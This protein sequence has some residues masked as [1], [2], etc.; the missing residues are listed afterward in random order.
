V[1][2]H[3]ADVPVHPFRK[4][5]RFFLHLVRDVSSSP[6]VECPDVFR[7]HNSLVPQYGIAAAPLAR[8]PG[9]VSTRSGENKSQDLPSDSSRQ[10]HDIAPFWQALES[11]ITSP[12]QQ[13]LWSESCCATLPLQGELHFVVV[14]TGSQTGAIAPLV[15]A[16]GVI[17]RLEH[18]GVRLLREPTDLVFSDPLVLKNLANSL[19]ELGSPLFLDRI[20]ADS[21]TVAAIREAYRGRGLVVIRRAKPYPRILL[22]KGWRKPESQL[23][24]GRRSDLR[25]AVRNAEKIGPLS[26]QILS[27]TPSQIGPILEEALDVEAA[28]WKGS[29]RSA[30]AN[31]KL[32][33]QFYRH[34]AAAA[35]AEGILR[36]CFLRVGSKAAAMQLALESAGSFW[37]LKIGYR[38]EFARCSPGMLLIAETIRC[39]ASR[40]L[41]SYEFLGNV[42]NWTRIWTQDEI[43][44]VTIR[45][46]PFR[47]RGVAALAADAFQAVRQRFKETLKRKKQ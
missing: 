44:S 36:V 10:L 34:Y 38:D 16:K 40:G 7:P 39:A 3:F 28:N 43:Q 13:R 1:L 29:E 33:G 23:N 14:K 15:R 20:P 17:G 19:V 11:E 46:Y 42:D 26:Y 8:I 30:I 6:Q 2:K 47:P 21:P 18:L 5:S 9:S 22:H 31:D 45:A 35:C 32:H 41:R 4:T 37:L 12:I 24:S 25:R 27:P